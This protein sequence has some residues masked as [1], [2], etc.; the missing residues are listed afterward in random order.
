MNTAG[1]L[2]LIESVAGAEVLF[3]GDTIID[4]YHYVTALNKSPKEN[5]IPVRYVS[6]ERFLGGV[7]A[8]ARHAESFCKRVVIS[9]SGSATKK[10]RFVEQPYTRKLFEIH[11][12]DGSGGRD[13]QRLEDFDCVV[14]ADFGHGEVN[15]T[16]FAGAKHLCVSAQTNSSNV[17]YNLITKYAKADYAVI[18]EPEARLAAADRDSPIEA[19]IEKL[20]KDRFG[21]MIVTQGRFGACGWH[22]GRFARLPAFTDAVVDTMGAG[23]AFFAITAPMSRTGSLEDLLIVG[24]AA[25]ALKT[26][27]VGHRS[28][29]TK[30]ALIDFIRTL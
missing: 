13:G 8:A 19:V 17:G 18:D 10:L 27:I 23:D 14:V 3:V 25:G 12:E 30:K 5:L 21:K 9:S 6:S 20:A 2:D 1:A 11:Y 22:D 24:N 16:A 7:D 28:S 4:E 15:D 29:V 26:Q